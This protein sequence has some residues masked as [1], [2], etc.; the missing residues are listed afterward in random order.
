V[1]RQ[2][3]GRIVRL[4]GNDV[5]FID[6]GLGDQ[7]TPGLTFEVFDKVEG[8]PP[9]GDPA[10]E[11]NLPQGKAS[12]EVIRVGPTSSE[13]RITRRAPG[14]ALSEGDLIVNLVYDRNTKYNFLVHG[15]FDLDQN[16]V[17]TSQDAEVIKRLITQWGGNIVGEINVDTDFVVLGKEPVIPDRPTEPDPIAQA[18]Y[19][20]AIAEYDVYQEISAKARTYRIPILN[21]N[22]FLYLV[23]YYEQAK[24]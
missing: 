13:C 6:L 19:E 18:N 17:A 20:R 4:P 10:T 3:D 9:P 11:E 5:A 7:V 8:I 23:G 24:R 1:T 12:L 14:A 2:P 21:Q 16:G 22:R 15:N